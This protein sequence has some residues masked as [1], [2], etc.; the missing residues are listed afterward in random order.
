MVL[1][2]VSQDSTNEV[3]DSHVASVGLGLVVIAAV[4]LANARE[5][6]WFS[7]GGF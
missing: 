3:I 6:M 4:K 7:P 5:S 2:L 1:I